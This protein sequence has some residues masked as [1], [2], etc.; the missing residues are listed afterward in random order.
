LTRGTLRVELTVS[1]SDVTVDLYRGGTKLA[2]GDGTVGGSVTLTAEGG[3][4]LSGSV[5]VAGGAAT[6]TETLTAR[7]PYSMKVKRGTSD[8][9]TVVVETVLFEGGDRHTWTEPEDLTAGETYYY[10][11]VPV[12]DTGTDGTESASASYT[13]PGPPV[14]PEDLA[15][16]SGNAAET[17]L[18]FTPSTTPASTHNVYLQQPGD[19]AMPLEPES[20]AVVDGSSIT[21]PAITGY[22]GTARVLV[23]AVKSGVEDA[24][25]EILELEYD[26]AG[27]YV[28]PRPNAPTVRGY[29]VASGLSASLLGVYP[30]TDEKAV[31]TKLNAY[32]KAPGGSYPGSPDATAALGTA[33]DGVKEATVAVTLASAGVWWIKVTAA[34]AGDVESEGYDEFMV[35]GSETVPGAVSPDGWAT[36]G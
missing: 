35:V 34:T 2:T 19:E 9:P 3:S 36:R 6:K 1:G 26:G 11:Y 17:V 31:A 24:N 23:R 22:A 29:S 27:D 7:W 12:S 30:T 33:Y 14:S 28:S 25:G 5:T 18:S 13:L 4:G 20:G 16:D 15:Y 32:V 8:P 21:L 10:R